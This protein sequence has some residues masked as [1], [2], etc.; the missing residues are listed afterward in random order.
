[1]E[2]ESVL[3]GS[4]FSTFEF[5][6]PEI[7]NGHI[8]RNQPAYS[9]MDL[10]EIHVCILKQ[11]ALKVV[12]ISVDLLEM[13][14]D[15]TLEMRSKIASSVDTEVD[16]V[17]LC[18]THCHTMP[19][20]IVLGSV[21]I[22]EQFV[23]SLKTAMFDLVSK[24]DS[25]YV[26][27]NV[28]SS[29][30]ECKGIGINRR[31]LIDG[32]IVMAPN[33]EGLIDDSVS[34][35]WFCPVGSNAP[36]CALVSHALHATTLDT[37]IFQVSADYPGRMRNHVRQALGDV[38]V[39]FF[40]GTCGDVRPNLIHE[41]GGFRGGFEKDLEDIGTELA[42]SVVS[43]F[44]SRRPEN[45]LLSCCSE[46]MNLKYDYK[47]RDKAKRRV[48]SETSSEARQINQGLLGAALNQWDKEIV[49]IEKTCKPDSVP[50]IC[51]CISI[52]DD[53][54]IVAMEGEMFTETGLKI[55]KSDPSCRV[56]I[57]TYANGSVGYV[58]TC[59]A[60]EN[61]GYEA[62]DAYKLYWKHAPFARDTSDRIA[63]VCS[64]LLK[65]H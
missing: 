23:H 9:F 42:A 64:K 54:K 14:S 28:F 13:D 20:A 8:N 55:K 44:A 26:P 1:M 60:L 27:C 31:K 62:D 12:L 32:Q 10:P 50:F 65:S 37:S 43:S 15:L 49:E 18:C 45:C 33:P 40:N 3:V 4:A 11:K 5:S 36:V 29:A 38:N 46:T 16:N 21:G 7:L 61:R 17:L 39:L 2:N 52:A 63:L 57:A 53:L 24:A 30:G 47:A 25:S 19:S 6:L 59:E 58:P 56:L 22:S 41:D 35:V 51:Q 48:L 34:S